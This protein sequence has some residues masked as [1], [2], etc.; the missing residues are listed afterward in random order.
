MDAYDTCLWKMEMEIQQIYNL[1]LH[2]LAV[3]KS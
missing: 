1:Y 3:N 2:Y